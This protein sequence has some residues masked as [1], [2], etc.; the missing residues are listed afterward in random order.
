M[1]TITL[2]IREFAVPVPRVGSIDANSG[3]GNAM[4]EGQEIH[5][6]VQAKRIQADPRYR[7]EVKIQ[8]KFERDGFRFEITGRM[9]GLF[10]QK[11]PKIEEI[12]ATFHPFELSKRLKEFPEHPYC[13][14]LKTYGYF[15]WLQ[16]QVVP[17]L[18]FH[19]VSIRNSSFED[20]KL[21]FDISE[22]ENW[23]NRRLEELAQEAMRTER[24]IQRRQQTAQNFAFPFE[25]PRTGQRELIQTI[26]EG[27]S[28]N[29]RM[30]V[31]APTGLGKTVGVLYPTLKEALSRGQ[32]VIYVTPKNSQHTVAE[33]AVERFQN[34]GAKIKSI[35]ITAKSKICLKNEP[36]CNPEYCEYAKD[37]YTKLHENKLKEVLERKRKLTAKA[38]RKLGEEYQVCPFE[39]QMEAAQD[40]DTVIC[41][42][43]YVFAPRGSISR[44][45]ANAIGQ[46]GKANLVIDEAHNLP[47][48]TMDYFSPSLSSFTLERMREDFRDLPTRFRTEAEELLDECIQVLIFCRPANETKNSKITP[49]VEPF[50][51]QDL[52]LKAFL[53]R[54]LDSDIEIRAKDPILRLCF[55]WSEFTAILE[56]ITDPKRKQFFTTFNPHTTGGIVK[57]TCCDA[58]EMLRERYDEYQ[59][60]VAFSATLK[61]FE[62]YAKLSG[63]EPEKIKFAE[64]QS[65]FA[66]ENRKVLIIPQVSTKWSDREKNYPKIAEAVR[67][68][69]ALHR[70]NYFV[71]FPSFEFM[72]RVVECFNTPEGFSVLVQE[73]DMKPSQFEAYLDHLRLKSMP[74][75]IFAVQ[76]GIFSEGVDYPGDMIIG[77]FV[78]GPPLPSFD[79]EREEMKKY[80]EEKYGSGFEYAYAY[81]AMSKAVQAAGRVIRSG[82]DQGLI[83]LL[84]SRFVQSPYTASMPTDWFSN[85]ASELVSSNILTEVSRFWEE[86]RG[87]AGET[88]EGIL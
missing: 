59:Q 87:R 49:V 20:L 2:A 83:V 45:N 79:L 58:S 88:N 23:L 6:R 43:N 57:V 21:P 67:R 56:Y 1:K 26:E 37:Y 38:F 18:S 53:S 16:N 9:D 50:L 86:A 31:Q 25:N 34:T 78:V 69:A 39:L 44:V 76:G 74:T 54:Y 5:Q 33:D 27:M 48:R 46:E 14:Q 11:S 61:P 36:L 64:F 4:S 22:Y 15:Y 35:T 30:L 19:L 71:F 12:K 24:R 63:L 10:E 70:G 62:Y 13:L 75:L 65:P 81:P 29:T 84:D 32:K 72:R 68:I 42:Y 82:E 77:A 3:Y 80:Y 41:D 8:Q 66:K 52:R 17:D 55:Y 40:A 60:V 28:A 47:A 51:E 7:P 85:H 73:R